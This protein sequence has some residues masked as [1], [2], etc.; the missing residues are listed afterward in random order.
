MD[1][2]WVYRRW[3]PNFVVGFWNIVIA[4]VTAGVNIF[5]RVDVLTGK[6]SNAVG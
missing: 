1:F 2:D 4:M 6:V 5:E 3:L